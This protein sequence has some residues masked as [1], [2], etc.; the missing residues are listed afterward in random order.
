MSDT[1]LQD[2]LIHRPLG[3]E[4]PY[5]HGPDERFPRHP[6]AGEIVSL[7]LTVPLDR[8]PGQL[9]CLW[10]L[11]GEAQPPLPMRKMGLAPRQASPFL[12]VSP[13]NEAAANTTAGTT[14]GPANDATL[15]EVTKK[16]DEQQL[17]WEASFG[18]FAYGD[19]VEYTF[20]T[21]PDS[22]AALS[23]EYGFGLRSW[24]PLELVSDAAGQL[25]LRYQG[26]SL[27]KLAAYTAGDNT[28]KLHFERVGAEAASPGLP[29][30][31][32]VSVVAPGSRLTLSGAPGQASL[33]PGLTLYGENGEAVLKSP[34][35]LFEGLLTTSG[36][37]ET[38]RLNFSEAAHDFY[39]LGERF[40]HL[41][42]RGLSP[43]IRVYEQY[44]DQGDRTY[45]PVSFGLSP[46]G[47][48]LFLDTSAYARF[49]L[50]QDGPLSCQVE[51]PGATLDLYLFSGEPKEILAAFTNL[52][53]KPALPPDWIYT[54][55][56]SG[57]EWNS[58]KRVM[59][60]LDRSAAAGIPVGVV[61][62]EAWADETTFYV[63]ND[64][65]YTPTNPARPT[66]LADFTFPA[67]GH[68]PDP[69]SM[70]DELHRRGIKLLLWQIPVLKSFEEVEQSML[71]RAQAGQKPQLDSLEQH[72]RDTAYAIEQGFVVLNA[73]GTPYKNPGIWFN[74]A[75]ILD[76]T[77]PA[78]R[79]W[80]MSKR[81][82]L[83][84]ELGVDGFKTDG[85]EHLWG[86]DLRFFDGR[87]GAELINA[88]PR[89]YAQMYYDALQVNGHMGVTFSRAGFTGSQNAPCHWAG[90]EN[91][92][93]AAFRHSIVAGL[94]AGLSGIPFW[95]WD[96]GG[97]SGPVPTSE[98]FLRAT[99]MAAF[100]PIM[101]YHS[102]YNAFRPPLRDRTPWNIAEQNGTPWLVEAFAKLARLRV[103]LIPYVA[104]VGRHAAATG[105]P[106][107]RALILDWPHD[108]ECRA[109]ED[110]YMLGSRYLVAPVV[111][112]GSEA[113]D[114]YLPE[115]H[116]RDYW[117]GPEAPTH[118][119]GRWLKD[120]P[121]PLRDKPTLVFER[122]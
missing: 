112:E 39:G 13:L 41:N 7:G 122:V 12:A 32:K 86:N 49:F 95:G 68:W 20:A 1:I 28:F 107:M 34:P 111:Y 104:E 66:R 61:V 67:N 70:I 80:W 38:L 11:N 64:A 33:T 19:R 120:Y 96:I 8:E 50:P 56:V 43:D 75:Y 101:Q 16:E 46:D 6:Q 45:F 117:D 91:S 102:E 87:R 35:G 97:F 84:E 79:A 119:G 57:N 31:G 93:F 3:F 2:L 89:L 14:A 4:A 54:L 42:Q 116:W 62:I 25:L 83:I 90:D 82:Y 88:F 72:R 47:F 121:A 40:D 36:E 98:L 52:T 55:W 58:Q 18:P 69:R 105:E 21:Q 51:L 78:A 17:C 103:E 22:T 85:G 100:C 74:G 99:G 73:D 65:T 29:F 24:Q 109:I 44:K 94:S 48:G 26:K 15:A 113:R 81:A 23:Y 76:I 37:L 77:N 71:E 92:T 59:D 110:Q 114:V 10:R 106:V 108:P 60:V 5:G 63:F 27:L 115:G 30:P 53:G 9:F 118:E